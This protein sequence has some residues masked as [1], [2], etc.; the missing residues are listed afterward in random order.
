MD[1]HGL[2]GLLEPLFGIDSHGRTERNRSR[3]LL[4][5]GDQALEFLNPVLDEDH[6]GHG[7]GFVLVV[8]D[9]EKSLRVE[10]Q[11][12]AAYGRAGDRVS[13][14]LKQQSRLAG[15][16]LSVCPDSHGPHLILPSVEKLFTVSC[17]Q[18]LSAPLVRDLVFPVE[19][20]EGPDIDLV[21]F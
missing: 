1:N 8:L 4:S 19:A 12:I 16:E 15:R 14:S 9:H 13:G 11:I 18:R 2:S 6:F 21:A 5:G 3:L 20:R 10:G 7:L 17:P